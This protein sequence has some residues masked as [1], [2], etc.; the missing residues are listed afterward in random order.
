VALRRSALSVV[1]DG[2]L[3]AQVV[4]VRTTPGQLRLVVRAEHAGRQVELDAV[5]PLDRRLAPDDIVRLRVDPTR[6]ATLPGRSPGRE[7]V[8]ERVLD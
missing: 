5:A 4:E 6:M 3:T 7:P 2:G 8:P 1:D